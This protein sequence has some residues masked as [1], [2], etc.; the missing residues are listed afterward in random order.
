[1]VHHDLDIEQAG[2][3]IEFG[4]AAPLVIVPHALAIVLDRLVAPLVLDKRLEEDS[5]LRDKVGNALQ[6]I[7]PRQYMTLP[8]QISSENVRV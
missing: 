4:I 1:M 6:S 2:S 3:G 7:Q 5:F 8:L